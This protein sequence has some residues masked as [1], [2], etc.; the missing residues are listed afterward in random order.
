MNAELIYSPLVETDIDELAA[1]LHNEAVHQYIGG[2]PSRP[3][4]EL[5]LRHSLSG[6]PP[7]ARGEH[8]I[9]VVVRTAETGKI[10]G[11]LEANLH[12]QLAE[13][14][15]LYNPKLWGYGYAMHGLLWLHHHLRERKD[16][17]TLWATAHPENQ[18]CAALLTKCGYAPASSRGLPLLYSYDEGDRVFNRSIAEPTPVRAIST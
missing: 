9:N 8:W 16:V 11:R 4:F 7:E 17:V 14:A 1:A 12:D 3:D 5:W 6:P 2:M 13:V 15:F 18:R 10:I